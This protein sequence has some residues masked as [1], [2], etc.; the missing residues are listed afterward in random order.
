MRRPGT[1]PTVVNRWSSQQAAD[2]CDLSPGMVGYLA[3]KGIVVPSLSRR[4]GKG[5]RRAYSYEDL[6]ILRAVTRLLEQGVEVTKLKADL[7]NLHKRYREQVRQRPDLKYLVTDG[8][9]AYLLGRDGLLEQIRT[10]QGVFRFVLD[11]ETLRSDIG[12]NSK[13]EKSEPQ[14]TPVEEK[15]NRRRGLVRKLV[16]K[17]ANV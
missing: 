3:R 10:G 4:E 5:H 8:A 12:P 7:V 13:A 1:T 6:V 16:S 9:A 17:A 14:R 15:K 2:R 11:V